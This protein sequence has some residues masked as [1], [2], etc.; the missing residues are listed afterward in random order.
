MACK[1]ERG[2]YECRLGGVRIRQGGSNDHDPWTV[3]VELLPI[4]S[5]AGLFG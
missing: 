1:E 4:K 2:G 3:E 5:K